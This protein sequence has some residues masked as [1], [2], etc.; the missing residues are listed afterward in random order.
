MTLHDVGDERVWGE[1]HISECGVAARRLAGRL[2]CGLW[3]VCFAVMWG[4]Q[5]LG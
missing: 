1:E 3:V 5:V 4:D 2:A